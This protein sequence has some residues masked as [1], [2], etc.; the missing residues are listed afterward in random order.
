MVDFRK[1]AETA[2]EGLLQPGETV[3]AGVNVT[4][5]PFTVANA[6]MIGGVV[7]GGMVGAAVGMAWDR[8]RR[9]KDEEA[10]AV[11]PLPAIA[12]RPPVEPT[13]S[14]NGGLLA[15]T[16]HRVLLWSVSGLGKPRDLLVAVSLHDVDEVVWQDLD[17]GW[18]SGRPASTALWIGVGERVL[19]LA[20][21]SMGPAGKAVRSVVATLGERRPGRV[22]EFGG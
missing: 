13:V 16:T 17:A 12:G 22:S 7:A 5:S 8:R 3:L 4:A 18:M 15:V 1:R 19:P 14:A 2:A 11:R 6:G 21:I 10:E 9:R 20:A